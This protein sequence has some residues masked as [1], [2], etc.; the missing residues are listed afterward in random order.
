MKFRYTRLAAAV[1]VLALVMGTSACGPQ[2]PYAQ[3]AFINTSD[4]EMSI[5]FI[6]NDRTDKT[7][8]LERVPPHSVSFH[9]LPITTFDVAGLDADS[10]VQ[11]LIETYTPQA[12]TPAQYVVFD[13]AGE[14]DYTIAN[15]KYLYEPG[16][17]FA[18]ELQKDSGGATLI[19]GRYS[20][21]KPFV[22][23]FAP[24]WPYSAL[25]KK[26]SALSEVW[27]LVPTPKKI[28]DDSQLA[29]AVDRYLRSL[30]T[31]R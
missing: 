3:A 5:S 14:Y 2:K 16:S 23:N 18:A 6:A 31:E 29:A 15:A 22:L 27:T 1:L 21:D 20:G 11:W 13:L 4:A 7:Y 25:P 10:R 19:N 8:I 30:D 17:S 24:V 28:D 9:P 12:T 26:V